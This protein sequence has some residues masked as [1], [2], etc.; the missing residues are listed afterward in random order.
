M[1][2]NR[3]QTIAWLTLEGW[4]LYGRPGQVHMTLLVKGRRGMWVLGSLNEPQLSTLDWNTAM[5]ESHSLKRGYTH[6]SV[7]LELAIRAIEAAE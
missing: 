3:E 4:E 6:S 5:I 7:C 2:M 1:K